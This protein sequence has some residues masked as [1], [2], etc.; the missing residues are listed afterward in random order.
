[1][2]RWLASSVGL[3]PDTHNGG[4]RMPRDC[5]ERFPCHQLQRKPPVSDPGMHHG[6]CVTHVLWCMSRSLTRGGGENIPGACAT[7]NFMYL[8]KSPW[9]SGMENRVNF[10]NW[11]QWTSFMPRG[12]SSDPIHLMA[13][14]K[15]DSVQNRRTS[16]MVDYLTAPCKAWFDTSLT[17]CKYSQMFS[18]KEM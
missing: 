4:L 11:W 3:L 6:T 17:R 12:Q 7:C 1:M 10:Q 2:C 16:Y 15:Q 13:V 9:R 5:R 18:I 14:L 8:V